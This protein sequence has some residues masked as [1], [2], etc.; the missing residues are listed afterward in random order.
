MSIDDLLSH[1]QIWQGQRG[2]AV[3]TLV[4]PTGFKALD[5]YLPGGG[6][7]LNVIT[8]IFLDRYGVGELS[9][10]MPALTRLSRQA[11]TA[12]KW[13]VWIGPPFI[14]YA[15]ALIR[16]GI[17]LNRIL[18]VHPTGSK[19]NVLWAAEQV[20]KSRS[21]AVVLAWL[22]DA[23]ITALRRMQLG[24]EEHKCW[25]VLFRP[26]VALKQSSP[27]QLRLKLSQASASEPAS[28]DGHVDDRGD[29]LLDSRGNDRFYDQKD[30]VRI[31]ILKCR[32]RRPTQIFVDNTFLRDVGRSHKMGWAEA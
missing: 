13:I 29:D 6:W 23:D 9:L 5:Q 24:A 30:R 8:E 12:K 4:V 11:I 16:C 32:G 31:D 7:P 15:P 26:A 27:A 20:I 19:K 10:L 1:P 3:S 28:A 2:D 22:Q 18:L 17:D 21:S 25:T 14:P